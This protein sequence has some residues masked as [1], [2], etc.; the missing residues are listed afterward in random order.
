MFGADPPMQN[1]EGVQI[2]RLQARYQRSLDYRG[3][4]NFSNRIALNPGAIDQIQIVIRQELDVKDAFHI[5]VKAL[6]Q[7]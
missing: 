6:Q 2:V 5:G 3:I 7:P 1:I 4:V